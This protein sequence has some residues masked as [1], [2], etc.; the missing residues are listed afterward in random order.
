MLI[1]KNWESCK[2]DIR[3]K[4][5]EIPDFWNLAYSLIFAILFLNYLNISLIK[6]IAIYFGV[7]GVTSALI[8]VWVVLIHIIVPDRRS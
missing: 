3:K 2:E 8:T 1:I 6:S 5:I 7:L 4:L